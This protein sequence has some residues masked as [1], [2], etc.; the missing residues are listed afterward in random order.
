M[1]VT[2]LQIIENHTAYDRNKFCPNC[3]AHEWSVVKQFDNEG[4]IQ[5]FVSCPQC[6][7]D[8]PDA[9]SRKI[10]IARWKQL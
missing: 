5:W 3:G 8:G 1:K 9:P 6:G 10:A 7:Y 4:D 2:Y